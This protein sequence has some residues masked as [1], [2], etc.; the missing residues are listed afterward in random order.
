MMNLLSPE[1]LRKALVHPMPIADAS[2]L[3]EIIRLRLEDPTKNPPMEIIAMGGSFVYGIEALGETFG[4]DLSWK[5]RRQ[6]QFEAAWANNLGQFIN[7]GLFHGR[8]VVHVQNL[9]VGGSTSDIGALLIEYGFL[10]TPGTVPDIIITAFSPNDNTLEFEKQ[11]EV[12]NQLTK[13]IKTMRC[14]GLP[15]QIS[16]VDLFD[17]GKDKKV[18]F[19][20]QTQTQA[21]LTHWYDF[22]G[23]SFEK[24]FQEVAIRDVPGAHRHKMASYRYWGN[25]WFNVHPGSI[26]HCAVC[27][28]L[29]ISLANA[30][31]DSCEYQGSTSLTSTTAK[32]AMGDTSAAWSLSHLPPLKSGANYFDVYDEWNNTHMDH[33]A[34]CQMQREAGTSIAKTCEYKWVNTKHLGVDSKYA[35][36]AVMQRV[37]ISNNGWYAEGVKH[38][39]EKGEKPGWVTTAPNADF[40]IAI[41]SES[42]PIRTVTII[43]MKSYGDKW[44]DS[45][46]NVKFSTVRKDGATED[47]AKNV[48]LVGIHNSN[49]SVNYWEKIELSSTA[50]PGDKVHAKFKMVGGSSFRINGLLFCSS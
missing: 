38:R 45:A 47:E 48:S 7:N 10:Q 25:P 23:L 29:T 14:D 31:V 44:K 32:T 36:D 2:K 39:S 35:A 15:V 22:M 27:W 21:V 49:T 9:G 20:E 43:Y 13:A 30:L 37:M 46:V 19:L 18:R 40:E 3:V 11:L 24:V 1:R 34:K 17:G 41:L 12:G 42:G 8:D 33:A 50:L 28:L 16:F 6:K 26:Y 5:L 4:I